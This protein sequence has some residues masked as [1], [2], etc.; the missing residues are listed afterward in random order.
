MSCLFTRI[1]VYIQMFFSRYLCLNVHIACILS[2]GSYVCR[3]LSH[4]L[5]MHRLRVGLL[6]RNMRIHIPF[7]KLWHPTAVDLKD[8]IKCKLA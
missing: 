1:H 6:Y 3:W 7:C 8:K 4:Y 2:T 5:C